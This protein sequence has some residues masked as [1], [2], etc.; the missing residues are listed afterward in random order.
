MKTKLASI[1]TLLLVVLFCS[2]ASGKTTEDGYSGKNEKAFSDIGPSSVS[3]KDNIGSSDQS[4]ENEFYYFDIYQM[5]IPKGFESNRM[6]MFELMSDNGYRAAHNN[7]H[8]IMFYVF[9]TLKS[10]DSEKENA[11][12]K[13]NNSM[14]SAVTTLN[15][16][17]ANRFHV[18]VNGTQNV[19]I[20]NHSFERRTGIIQ[21]E[22]NGE[23]A[24]VHYIGYFGSLDS[25]EWNVKN[26]ATVLFGFTN[27][28]DDTAIKELET[29]IDHAADT[30]KIY[31]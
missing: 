25:P 30:M 13:I 10:I 3:Q 14:Y 23:K 12:D 7:E 6:G 20:L 15:K 1:M 18:T 16:C 27:G 19:E 21:T 22:K 4:Y 8:R 11:D 29:I 28:S 9:N 17:D 2:C 24:E 5:E 26:G 31:E